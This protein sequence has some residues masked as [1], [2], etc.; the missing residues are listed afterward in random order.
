MGNHPPESYNGS[1]KPRWTLRVAPATKCRLLLWIGFAVGG[2]TF[3]LWLFAPPT[4]RPETI[5][6]DT[7]RDDYVKRYH[8]D[9]PESLRQW[10]SFAQSKECE[11]M[12]FYDAIHRDLDVFRNRKAPLKYQTPDELVAEAAIEPQ[13]FATFSIANHRLT[14]ERLVTTTW[15]KDYTSVRGR[16]YLK[17]CI[18]WLMH[19]L[20]NHKP[21]IN[22]TFFLNL[23]D[24]PVSKT[25][26]MFPIFSYSQVSYE[27]DNLTPPKENVGI[28]GTR[29]STMTTT[30]HDNVTRDLLIPY[31]LT[32]GFL[33]RLWFWPFFSPGKDFKQRQDTITWRG[34]TTGIWEEG[35]RFHLLEHYGGSGVHPLSE[36]IPVNV[37]FAFH[38]VIFN[39][40]KEV[41]TTK[42]RIALSI[43]YRGM[44][45]NKYVLDV[46]GYG[47]CA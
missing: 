34:S 8:R 23:H 17:Y 5:S 31:F 30:T 12:K 46:D 11:T 43:P 26:A 27:N 37:D 41:D 19:P 28:T 44:Q 25:D 13:S 6:W 32:M 42:Y 35:H 14:I 33:S 1:D 3:R 10:L 47:T 21:P 39:D 2:L 38:N 24:T 40:G 15:P 22:N 7:F 16:A 36:T 4:D 20:V 18:R 45:E 9:P 29:N